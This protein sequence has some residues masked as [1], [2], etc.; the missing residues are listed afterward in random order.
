MRGSWR[1]NR[2][3]V[4]WP[5]T[6]MTISVSFLFSWCC[7]IGGLALCWM[8]FSLPHLITNG[9]PNSPGVRR[10][11]STGW[12]LSLPHFVSNSSDHQL[13]DFLSSQSYIIVQSPSQSLE[14][15]VWSPSSGN[16]CH[17]VQRSLSSGASVYE[18][19]MG[20]YRVPFFSQARLRD[21]FS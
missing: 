18:Y 1:P 5:P 13:T 6:L 21:F 2:T 9:S 7:S 16:N 19:T 11:P 17:V 8:L 12:W 4:Y 20:F 3:A 10:A 14:R 15:H